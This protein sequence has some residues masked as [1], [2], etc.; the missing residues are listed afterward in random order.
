MP[1]PDNGCRKAIG[2]MVGLLNDKVVLK[3]PARSAYEIFA[4]REL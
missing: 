2:N 3:A 4:S 1:F